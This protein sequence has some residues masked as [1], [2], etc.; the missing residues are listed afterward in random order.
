M[1]LMRSSVTRSSRGNRSSIRS[2]EES[3][4][5]RASFA[6]RASSAARRMASGASS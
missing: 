5:L 4:Y 6:A 3:F 1:S 2:P